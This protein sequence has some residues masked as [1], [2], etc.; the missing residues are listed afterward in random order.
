MNE[1]DPDEFDAVAAPGAVDIRNLSVK[2]GH[3][4]TYQTLNSFARRDDWNVYSYIC[5]N[6]R[7]DPEVTETLVEVPIDLDVFAR[8]DP[9]WGGGRRH[10][11]GDAGKTSRSA[12][13]SV[14]QVVEY[15]P[16]TDD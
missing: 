8:R 14:L 13:D 6:D 15:D 16:F 9:G 4:E 11:G 7:C 12:E 10:A 3:C 1:P 2:C 5:E